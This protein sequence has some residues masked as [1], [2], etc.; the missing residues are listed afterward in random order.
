MWK[1]SREIARHAQK[2]VSGGKRQAIGRSTG[3]IKRRKK[4]Q[5]M[6]FVAPEVERA[7]AAS[8]AKEKSGPEIARRGVEFKEEPERV[9][10]VLR[11]RIGG[12]E[13]SSPLPCASDW[14]SCRLSAAATWPHEFSAAAIAAAVCRVL[15][16][17]ASPVAC[18]MFEIR[19]NKRREPNNGPLRCGSSSWC[20]AS[21]RS[22][23]HARAGRGGVV[24]G[25]P[26]TR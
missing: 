2:E 24:R 6:L 20:A 25:T 1:G 19:G 22:P 21:S 13:G 26:P 7:S 14:P 12:V 3:G 23:G 5:Y 4:K 15:A 9:H 18:M 10:F 17:C 8:V 16:A 11:S